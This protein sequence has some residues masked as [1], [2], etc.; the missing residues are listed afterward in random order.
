MLNK[1]II[2][3]SLP[4]LYLTMLEEAGVKVLFRRCLESVEKEGSRIVS[5][6]MDTGE[7]VKAKVFVDATY[8]GDLFAG[9]S[10]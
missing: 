8:E 4:K 1:V 10:L 3:L 2:P 7:T 9:I 6:T 5:A